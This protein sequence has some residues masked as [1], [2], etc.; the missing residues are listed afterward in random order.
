MRRTVK[1]CLIII[2]CLFIFFKPIRAGNNLPYSVALAPVRPI[3]DVSE[4]ELKDFQSE[5]EVRLQKYSDGFMVISTEFKEE[6]IDGLLDRISEL[7]DDDLRTFGQQNVY[8]YLIISEI[9]KESGLLSKTWRGTIRVL[10]IRTRVP[11]TIKSE[12][13]EGIKGLAKNLIN[14]LYKTMCLGTISINVNIPGVICSLNNESKILDEKTVSIEKIIGEYH[15]QLNKDKYRIFDTTFVL[16]PGSV[17]NINQKM[18]KRGTLVVYDGGPEGAH[19]QI[20]NKREKLFYKLPFETFLPEGNYQVRA[21][22]PG[23]KSYSEKI[24]V[25][26]TDEILNRKI[27][28][29]PENSLQ[30]LVNSAVMPGLGQYKMGFRFQGTLIF[31][32]EITSLS[33]GMISHYYYWDLD[34]QLDIL[35]NKYYDAVTQSEITSLR[36]EIEDKTNQQDQFK[37]LRNLSFGA[38]AGVYIY[39][40]VDIVILKNK[41]QR[42]KQKPFVPDD[43]IFDIGLNA[44]KKGI[45]VSWNYYIK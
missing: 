43:K 11:I 7:T 26:D 22:C 4:I 23:Y 13:S 9:G 33:I 6:L 38:A 34:N 17:I 19:V 41:P 29:Q 32:G 35:W 45:Q 44:E 18:V 21:S 30:Y 31:L 24:D 8:D 25:P 42:H 37:I 5:M 16:T 20:S 27:N 2:G 12:S 28:L 39:N 40:I 14:R 36:N 1:H 10:D 15:L 3:G